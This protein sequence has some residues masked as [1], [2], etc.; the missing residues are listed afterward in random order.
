MSA[1]AIS[2]RASAWPSATRRLIETDFLLRAI[3]SHHTGSPRPQT[4]MGSPAP[5]GS[6]LITSAPMSP[7][8]WPQNGPAISVPISMTRRSLSAPVFSAPSLACMHV[9]TRDPAPA[10]LGWRGE[11]CHERVLP[12]S[13]TFRTG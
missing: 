8:S 1:L 11:D 7:I 5:G 2:R 3:T 12:S 4:R 10:S 9:L 13:A 6:I